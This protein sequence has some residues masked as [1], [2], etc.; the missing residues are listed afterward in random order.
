MLTIFKNKQNR[1]NDKLFINNFFLEKNSKIQSKSE[2]D[3]Y[4]NAIDYPFSSKEWFTNIYSYNKSYVKSLIIYDTIL[5]K[6]LKSYCNMLQEKI[7][8]LFK[9]RRD[10]K[11]R[12]SANRLYT[13]RAELNYTNTTIFI[14]LYLYNKQKSYI[15]HDIRRLITWI[16]LKKIMI[17]GKLMLI[18]NHKNRLLH[19]LKNNFFFFKK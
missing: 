9:R 10:N 19:L 16:R 1:F 6:L 3:E 18:P 4:N 11:T 2:K 8:I 14:T 7:K 15:E 17:E 13:S 12:Y 5:N